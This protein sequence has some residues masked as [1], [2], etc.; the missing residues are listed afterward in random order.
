MAPLCESSQGWGFL[1]ADLSDHRAVNTI[2]HLNS[3]LAAMAAAASCCCSRLGISIVTFPVGEPRLYRV[4]QD[5]CVNPTRRNNTE[6][7][8]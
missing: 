8:Q 5:G 1:C 6:V 3:C 2:A 4:P 7:L